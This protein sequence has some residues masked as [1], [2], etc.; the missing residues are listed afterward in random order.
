MCHCLR[1]AAPGTSKSLNT[2]RALLFVPLGHAAAS[3]S[4]ASETPWLS[5]A[6]SQGAL[7]LTT[8]CSLR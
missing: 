1:S 3:E 5:S 7:V 8:R 6:Q 2:N 4:A